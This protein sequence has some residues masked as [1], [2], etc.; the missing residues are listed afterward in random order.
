MSPLVA[1]LFQTLIATLVVMLVL[2]LVCTLRRDVSLVDIYW[3]PGFLLI[4]GLATW[5]R[6]SFGSRTS[7]MLVMVAIWGLR[8]ALYL[9][10]RKW[11]EG[12]DRRYRA[13]R[14][15]H[16][17]RFWWVSLLTVF[18]LQGVLM[19]TISIPLQLIA[20]RDSGTFP[21][22]IDGVGL[23]LWLTGFTF[24]VVGDGQLMR[25]QSKPDHRHRVMDRG[26]W[27][28]TRHPNYFGEFLMWWGLWIVSLP[29]GGW[30]T[31][32]SPLLMTGLLLKVSGVSLL[33]STIADRRPEYAE[34]QRRTSAFLPWPPRA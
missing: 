27:R 28:Y 19:W 8:L 30:W 23:C 16:G 24:E 10:W 1:T 21:N 7:A 25:F 34:Y 2:W 33:E 17:R 9:V 6:S 32:F 13:M 11:G 18:L 20:V 15:H 22:V 14:E 4:A 5:G 3:G 26:V 12:E 29:V 31:I